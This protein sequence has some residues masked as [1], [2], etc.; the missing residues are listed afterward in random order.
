K[1]T[2]AP[3]GAPVVFSGSTDSVLT[4]QLNTGGNIERFVVFF[5]N[6]RCYAVAAQSVAEVSRPLPVA[7][8]PRSPEWLAGVANL[9]GE[10]IPVLNS[11]KILSKAT[12]KSASPTKFIILRAKIFSS[13]IAL[14]VDRL[15]EI[16]AF[17]DE[18]FDSANDCT[19]AFVLGEIAYQTTLLRVIDAEALLASIAF[20]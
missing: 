11:S 18:D 12:A 7:V 3:R 10:I 2:G 17:G 4:E 5:L 15:S 6:T 20:D 1:T 8:L 16:V 19:D 13:S 14:P 9:R